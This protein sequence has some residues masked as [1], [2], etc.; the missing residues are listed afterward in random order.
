MVTARP[1][2]ADSDCRDNPQKR[3]ALSDWHYAR[4]QANKRKMQV[5]DQ[6]KRKKAVG[7]EEDFP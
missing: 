6:D 2:S 4:N 7:S 5:V 1:D 3:Q